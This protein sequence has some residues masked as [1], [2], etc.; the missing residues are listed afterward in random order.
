MDYAQFDYVAHPGDGVVSEE[1][2][3]V[4]TVAEQF[5]ENDFL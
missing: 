1:V 2:L 5:Y 4:L 3:K